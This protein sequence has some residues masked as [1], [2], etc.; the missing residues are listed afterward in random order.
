MAS[1]FRLKAQ[2]TQGIDV[3]A[4]VAQAAEIAGLINAS[5]F[6][7]DMLNNTATFT[8]VEGEST[9]VVGAGQVV[10]VTDGV[11]SVQAREEFYAKFEETNG[12][13]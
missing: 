4:P 7:V 11:V 10:S 12:G 9:I 2:T 13:H 1:I 5:S 8:A 3:G 6:V